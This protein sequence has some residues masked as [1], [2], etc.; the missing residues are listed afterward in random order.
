MK[1]FLDMASEYL[2]GKYRCYKRKADLWL[3]ASLALC[4]ITICS[5]YFIWHDQAIHYVLVIPLLLFTAILLLCITRD[6]YRKS[7]IYHQIYNDLQ[8]IRYLANKEAQK[9]A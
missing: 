6:L 5:A 8:E 1:L 7:N 4:L 9:E 2:M 3:A